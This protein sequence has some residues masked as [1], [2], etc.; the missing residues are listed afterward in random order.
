[1]V[2]RYPELRPA[3]AEAR[4]N[5]DGF[6]EGIEW[7]LA[8]PVDEVELTFRKMYFLWY[9][10]DEAVRWN[11]GHGERDV[12]PDGVRDAMIVL[13]NTYYWMVMLAAAAGIGVILL[14]H[15]D[16]SETWL[17]L[18]IVVYWT[19]AHIAFFGDPRFH[20]PVMPVAS[21]LTGVAL[22]RTLPSRNGLA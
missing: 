14:R 21:L 4:I 5:R 15:R 2:F 10:D 19:L 13:S 20:A 16:Q 9:R 18:S 7:A 3:A 11:D 8:H 17:L 1:L 12:M 22:T 6:R